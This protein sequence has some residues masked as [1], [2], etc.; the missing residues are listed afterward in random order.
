MMDVLRSP[1]LTSQS[2]TPAEGLNTRVKL[3]LSDVMLRVLGSSG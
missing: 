3:D 2:Q 1:G